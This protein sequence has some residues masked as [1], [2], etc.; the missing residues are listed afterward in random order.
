MVSLATGLQ[1]ATRHHRDLGH[2]R[3]V[4]GRQADGGARPQDTAVPVAAL[5]GIVSY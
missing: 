5:P 3:A 1:V 2:G 4:G